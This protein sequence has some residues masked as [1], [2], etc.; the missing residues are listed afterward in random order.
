[1]ESDTDSGW[2][3]AEEKV[4]GGDGFVGLD[5]S[6]MGRVHVGHMCEGVSTSGGVHSGV[7]SS[8]C[9]CV[10]GL[11]SFAM[12]EGVCSALQTL[13]PRA[14]TAFSIASSARDFCPA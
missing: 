8:A 14:I 1:V 4:G 6:E 9:D 12:G 13:S 10:S 11:T 5:E 3:E 2:D 7:R